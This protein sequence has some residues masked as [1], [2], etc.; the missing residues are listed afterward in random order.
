MLQKHARLFV[1]LFFAA[2]A[3]HPLWAQ[4]GTYTHIL[5]SD[6][7]TS[8]YDM[9]ITVNTDN[10]ATAHVLFKEPAAA[11]QQRY[12]LQADSAGV[13]NWAYKLQQP[14]LLYKDITN[15]SVIRI[16]GGYFDC[17]M[18]RYDPNLIDVAV[19][20]RS[21]A[22]G[23]PVWAKAFHTPGYYPAGDP[24]CAQ[25]ND[26]SFM[27]AADIYSPL[28]IPYVNLIRIDSNGTALWSNIYSPSL[29][30]GSHTAMTTTPAQC[31]LVMAERS[32]SAGLPGSL[33]IRSRADGSTHWMNRYQK[34]NALFPVGIKSSTGDSAWL[35]CKT[36][37]FLN[38]KNPVIIKTDSL[39]QVAW[40]NEYAYPNH[41]IT[42]EGFITTADNGLITFG[43]ILSLSIPAHS[44]LMKTDAQGNLVWARES[45]VLRIK[46]IAETPSGGIAYV[47]TDINNNYQLIMGR[48]DA[49]GRDDCDT[50]GLPFTVQPVVIT[51]AP[52]S[53]SAPVSVAPVPLNYT[54][55]ALPFSDSALCSLTSSVASYPESGALQLSPNPAGNTVRIS[56]LTYPGVIRIYNAGGQLCMQANMQAN[57]QQFDISMLAEGFYAVII[58]SGNK[59]TAKK[60][61]IKR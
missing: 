46:S 61:I 4:S 48:K 29:S 26:G 16:P 44:Y 30:G 12:V 24:D 34:G 49:Q 52:D 28:E 1:L 27:I 36:P 7:A 33:V 19:C 11:G 5:A 2:T 37:D 42:P 40:S 32:D 10:S 22:N 3:T 13:I 53:V 15:T 47:A 31:A 9:S 56:G 57:E 23:I 55:A 45:P 17:S 21:D 35:L 8:A 51:S 60:L 18:A 50:A 43:T 58:D 39:G 59:R 20:I 6:S 14:S 25:L 41:D 38:N 54:A